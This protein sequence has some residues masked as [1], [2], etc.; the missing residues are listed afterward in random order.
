MQQKNST[1]RKKAL[2]STI[3]TYF[4]MYRRR[5]EAQHGPTR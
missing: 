3:A 2:L 4:L 5:I 1:A